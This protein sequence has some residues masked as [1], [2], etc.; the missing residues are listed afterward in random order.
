LSYLTCERCFIIRKDAGPMNDLLT[1]ERTLPLMRASNTLQGETQAESKF[2]AFTG[3]S[4]QEIFLTH[5]DR[6]YQLLVRMIGDPAE[7]EDLALETFLRLYQHPPKAGEVKLH[8]KN[9]N[10]RGRRRSWKT[11][12]RTASPDWLSVA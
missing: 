1:H 12:R 10:R 3:E 7:A 11:Q 2:T 9:L 8:L 5:W 4:F 6:I